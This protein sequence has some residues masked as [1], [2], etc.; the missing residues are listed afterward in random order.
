MT[1]QGFTI[2]ELLA[3]V[4][5]I[6]ILT[7]LVV[8]GFDPIRARA[9]GAVCLSHMRS[10]HTSLATY[11]QDKGKWPQEPEGTVGDNLVDADWWLKELAPYDAPPEIW[12]CPTI[13]RVSAHSKDDNLPRIHY[14]PGAFDDLPGSPFKYS[15]QPW[16]V[17]VAGVHGHGPNICFPDG[18][19]R[20]MDD[21]LKKK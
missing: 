13:K 20:T 9:E 15:M 2:V 11:V 21:L 3:V 1:H 12:I 17:E 18:S 10:L 5:V 7:F 4:F 16:L 19:I 6:S 8:T 14:L